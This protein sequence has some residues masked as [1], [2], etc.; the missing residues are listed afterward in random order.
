MALILAVD[1]D[2][3]ILELIKNCL[4][5]DN[6]TVLTYTSPSLVPLDSLGKYDLILLDIM[7][8]DIDGYMFCEKIRPLVDCPILFLSAKSLENDIT[9]GLNLGADDYLLKPFRL[10]ELKARVNAHLRRES[11]EKHISLYSGRISLN[12][13][14]KTLLVD[15]DI[16][17]LTKSEYLLCEFLLRNKGQ[18]FSKEQIYE[19]V[20]SIYGESDNSTITTHVKN[21]R[22]KLNS[23]DVSSITTVWGIGYKWD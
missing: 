10:S 13:S 9:F 2:N 16:I 8:P 12:L 3:S 19:A 4:F 14:A 17:A 22:I 1:D 20:F 18:V 5:K 23:F 21:I 7:M 6:H 15:Q 11:R